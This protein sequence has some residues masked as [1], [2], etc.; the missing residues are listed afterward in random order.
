MIFCFVLPLLAL[1]G[2][3]VFVQCLHSVFFLSFF[4]SVSDFLGF[5]L[6]KAL[7]SGSGSGI[8]LNQDIEPSK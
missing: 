8:Q 2:L 5:L 1:G 4:H 7:V 3:F 6:V